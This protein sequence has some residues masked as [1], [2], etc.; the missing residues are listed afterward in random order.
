MR[1]TKP[2]ISLRGVSRRF[3]SGT[4]ETVTVLDDVDLD[5]LPGTLTVIRGQ[6]GSGKTTLMRI[7]G[8]LDAEFDGSYTL[9]GTAVDGQPDWTLDEMRSEN[10]GFIFQE[11]RLF[12][13]LT[14]RDNISVSLMLHGQHDE[15]A[16]RRKVD[17]LGLRIFRPEEIAS[18][19]LNH[20][21]SHVSGGQKQRASIMRAMV[22]QPCII[23][24]DEPTAS[25]H[26]DLKADIVAQLHALC[27]IGHTVIVVSHDEAFYDAGRQLELERGRLTEISPAGP[28]QG[29]VIA[30]RP[31]A[32]GR[33][34]LWGWRP[35]APLDTLFRQ[36]LR[37]T[38]L[39]PIF[40][41]LILTSLIVGVCQ[42][43][44]FGSVILGT[45]AFVQQKMTEGSRL[46]R[47][48]IQ[49]RAADRAADD[50]FP[51][52]DEIAA[53]ATITDVVPRRSTTQN[54]VTVTGEPAPFSAI[55][56]LP[57]DP[58]YRLLTFVAGSAF[59]GDHDQLEVIVTASL[60]PVLFD[61]SEMQAGRQGFDDFLGR[62]V[63]I[64][65]PRF[66]ASGD[67]LSQNPVRV[68]IRGIILFGEGGRQ[69]YLP[70]TTQLVFD[71]VKR[72]RAGDFPFPVTA[73]GRAWVNL[74]LVATM[75][76]FPW[77]DRLHIYSA[78]IREIIPTYSQ[79]ARMGYSP[80][81]D[82][83][84]FKWAL[85]IQDTAW[86]IFIPLLGLIVIVVSLTVFA[87][88]FTSSKL[89][90]TEL[91]LWRVLGMRRGDLVLTQVMSTV[92]SVA[93]GSVLGLLLGNVLIGYIR[94]TLRASG[95]E[96]AIGAEAQNFDAIFVD[97]WGFAWPVMGVAIVLGILASLYPAFRASM[98]DP[99]R[100]LRA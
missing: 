100:V 2:I 32:G 21:P 18:G 56:L 70:N 46:N 59:S 55:G 68:A 89:R 83:W 91:A 12:E 10:L 17:A 4:G 78:E 7:L 49:P 61:T 82:I 1:P 39:R 64:L 79:L 86:K 22:N 99:A 23:L 24:A 51:V 63:E 96:V 5:I 65:V 38:F 3:R 19:L 98:V 35:R 43:S 77:E 57:G 69:L 85:D 90:E 53:S 67:I 93:L 48:E 54:V 27:A 58:E 97:V 50:R 71:R 41:F 6:S 95:Q 11:G 28:A 33:S 26:N 62:E 40:L 76:D 45:D 87:N 47:I 80:V 36:A 73:D 15:F 88:I 25:L 81:S 31:P 20:L 74:A 42:V 44:V 75:A 13:H 92:M 60:L 14:L 8:M 66:A 37:E 30:S 29:A 84:S 52:R 72:D 94:D 16:R 34:I 9:D